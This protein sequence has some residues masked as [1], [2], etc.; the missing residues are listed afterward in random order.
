MMLTIFNRRELVT[1]SDQSG[2]F[3][4]RE[5]LS[6]AKIASSVKIHGIAQAAER[7]R[8]GGTKNALYSYTVYVHRDDHDK[9]AAVIRPALRRE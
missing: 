2:L 4:V 5:A 7:A 6:S 9:A 1:L 3:R 8:Y